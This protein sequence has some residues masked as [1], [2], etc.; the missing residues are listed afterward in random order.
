MA[1]LRE[2]HQIRTNIE[3]NTIV[4]NEHYHPK[5]IDC[6]VSKEKITVELED[7]REISLPIDLIVKD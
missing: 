6:Q 4:H 5:I 1:R 3:P 7:R 2:N